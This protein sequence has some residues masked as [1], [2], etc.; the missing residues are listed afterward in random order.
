MSIF[1]TH[2]SPPRPNRFRIGDTW[3]GPE[4]RPYVVKQ[5]KQENVV[6]LQSLGW[7]VCL[8]RRCNDTRGFQRTQWGG[9]A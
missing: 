1:S 2:V 9:Q 8:D 7:N 4:G 6:S 3:V 5:G